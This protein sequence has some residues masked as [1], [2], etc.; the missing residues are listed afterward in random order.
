MWRAFLLC[1]F[2]S[3]D[4]GLGV[5][6]DVA[7]QNVIPKVNISLLYSYSLHEQR[8]T[9]QEKG[10]PEGAGAVLNATW[11]AVDSKHWS[12]AVLS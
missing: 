5:F 9:A 11:R 10:V 3:V 12:N 7:E 6:L 8:S 4:W 1:L 2:F